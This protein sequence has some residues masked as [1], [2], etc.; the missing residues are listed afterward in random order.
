MPSRA[1]RTPAASLASRHLGRP[2]SGD[3]ARGDAPGRKLPVHRRLL[4]LGALAA[5]AIGLAQ[6]LP[7]V[8]ASFSILG[9]LVRLL[10]QDRVRIAV[11]AGPEADPHDFAPRPSDAAQLAGAALVVRNG[12]GFEPWLDPLLRATR[13]AG[14]VVTASEGLPPRQ[15]G[16][17]QDPHAWLDLAAARH[18]LARLAAGLPALQPGLP[19]ADA[20]LA[21]LDA[22]LRSQLQAVPEARR[23]IAVAHDSLGWFGAAYGLEVLAPRGHGAAS[24]AELVRQL[25]NRPVAG[26]F[27]TSPADAALARRVGAE[28]GMPVAGRLYVETLSAPG[29]PAPDFAALVRHN[30]GLML[31][32]MRG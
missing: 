14:P 30:A 28:V 6:P 13:P 20:T 7:L 24:V 1:G 12:F 16:S 8:L 27:S 3:S 11:L 22:W 19:A 18:Y 26:L 32:A 4:L 21:A 2:P 25:R 17:W 15:R 10:G 29:G 23:A 31:A 9:D 5:P